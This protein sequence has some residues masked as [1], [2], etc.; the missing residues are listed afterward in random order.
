[1]CKAG[2]IR[3]YISHQHA[4]FCILDNGMPHNN[5]QI[6]ISKINLC[7]KNVTQFNRYIKN[8]TCDMV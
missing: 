6:T 8:E 1:M 3:T 5:K 4:I 7:D 2:I